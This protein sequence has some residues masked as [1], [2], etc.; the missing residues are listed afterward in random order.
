MLIYGDTVLS[1]KDPNPSRKFLV[2][3]DISKAE[4]RTKVDRIKYEGYYILDNWEIDAVF[5]K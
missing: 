4:K 3:V 2:I 1:T 5:K